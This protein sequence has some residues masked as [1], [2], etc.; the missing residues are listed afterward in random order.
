MERR[1]TQ[2]KYYLTKREN[3]RLKEK[4]ETLGIKES[5][6]VRSLIN[7]HNPKG[8]PSKELNRLIY[9]INRIG[10]NI[11]Q[12][13]YISNKTDKVNFLLLKSYKMELDNIISTLKKKYIGDS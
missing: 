10:N 13:A 4:C 3:Q 8:K 9:E 1:N 2:K 7:G 11:N 5:E 12:I 6:Y